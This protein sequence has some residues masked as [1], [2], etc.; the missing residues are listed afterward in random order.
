MTDSTWLSWVISWISSCTLNREVTSVWGEHSDWFTSVRGMGGG[1]Q[2]KHFQWTWNIRRWLNE[3][4][5]VL[6]IVSPFIAH[7]SLPWSIGWVALSFLVRRLFVRSSSCYGDIW[8][9]LH[10]FNI[11]RHRSPILTQYHLIPSSTKLYWPSTQSTN[12]YRPILT[13]YHQILTST[14]F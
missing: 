6:I 3:N 12:Q 11:Y 2:W 14:D 13:Q 8:L 1:H 7:L 5:L 10:F 4:L 9:N